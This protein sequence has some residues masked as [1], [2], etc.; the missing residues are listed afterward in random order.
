MSRI[1]CGKCKELHESVDEV[2]ACFAVAERTLPATPQP[3]VPEWAQ[4]PATERQ[5]GLLNSLMEEKERGGTELP[6]GVS[7]TCMN[8]CDSKAIG[9]KEAS[10]AIEA[11]LKLPRGVKSAKKCDKHESVIA[12]RYALPADDGHVVFYQVDRP[13][14]GRWNGYVFVKTLIGGVGHWTTYPQKEA[15]GQNILERIEKFG[16][17]E[18]AQLF[19]WKAKHCGRCMSP[20]SQIQSRAAGYGAHCAGLTGWPYPTKEEARR[21]LG[22]RGESVEE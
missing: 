21:M 7:E 18:S 1:R 13:T 5:L 3:E 14:E 15:A 17:R 10:E 16:V 11:L 22:E 6:D 19:G 4:H 8:V 9:K 20:L 12:G 2:R